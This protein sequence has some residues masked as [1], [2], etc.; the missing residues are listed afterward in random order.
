[1]PV[2]HKQCPKLPASI[3]ISKTT[4][5][6]VMEFYPLN[7]G[8]SRRRRILL[9]RGTDRG[10][11]VHMSLLDLLG[12]VLGL[13]LNHLLAGELLLLRLTGILRLGRGH[14]DIVVLLVVRKVF[15]IISTDEPDSVASRFANEGQHGDES[16]IGEY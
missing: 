15:G 13:L 5:I 4:R 6:L 11:R 7:L 1:M 8:M 12:L 16:G 14:H 9:N 3:R 10:R 2:Y